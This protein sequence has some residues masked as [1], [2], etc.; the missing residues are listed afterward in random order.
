MSDS[1]TTW[2]TIGGVGGV[3]SLLTLVGAGWRWIFNRADRREA[4]LDK[5]EAELVAKMEERVAALEARDERREAE[6]TELRTELSE[7]RTEL[8]DTRTALLLLAQEV[9]EHNPQSPA[10][11]LARKLLRER[12]PLDPNTPADMVETVLRAK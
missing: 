11:A 7:T 1:P 9:A 2:Q 3:V 8:S 5:R 6:V 4:A 10:L 12:F